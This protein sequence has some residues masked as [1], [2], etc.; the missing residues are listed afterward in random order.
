MK[1]TAV[2][3]AL[4][5]FTYEDAY[6]K[7]SNRVLAFDAG[8]WCIAQ[9]IEKNE[10]VYNEETDDYDT[11]RIQLW[12]PDTHAISHPEDYHHMQ[13]THWILLPEPIKAE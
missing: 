8:E 6:R 11:K 13:V 3:E 5:P 2:T 10:T 4:P 7:Q 12:E 1:A 9:Y